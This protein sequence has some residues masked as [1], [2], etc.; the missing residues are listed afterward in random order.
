MVLLTMDKVEFGY[1]DV[2]CLEDVSFQVSAG[3]FVAVT[4]PNGSSKSTLLKLAL[5]L[6]RP[7]KGEVKLQGHNPDGSKLK[8]GYVPQHIVAFNSGFPSRVHEFVRSGRYAEGSWLRR[9]KP[10]DHD[11]VEKSLRDVGMW[12]MRGRK[13][14]ELSGGQKQRICIARAMAR[15]PE[16]LVMD[17]PTAGMD[18]Q[19]RTSFYTQMRRQVTQYNRTVIIVTHELSEAGSFLDRTIELTRK[20]EG[21]WK[22]CTTTLCSGHFGLAE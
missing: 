13:I 20:E 14:G 17:E 1:T 5:G 12:E 11:I 18:L 21:A 8:I 6:L 4:G 22:C 15:E 19:S 16:L 7:Q 2:P 9:L 3:E 10:R